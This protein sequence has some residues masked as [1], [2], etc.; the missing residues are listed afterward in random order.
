[1]L[2]YIRPGASL[3]RHRNSGGANYGTQRPPTPPGLSRP[4]QG[5]CAG[6]R[7]PIRLPQ[8]TPD[9]GFVPGGS[10]GR[11]FKSG[12]PDQKFPGQKG[13]P[14]YH[15]GPFSIFGSQSGSL[16]VRSTPVNAQSTRVRSARSTVIRSRSTGAAGTQ[17]VGVSLVSAGPG[18]LRMRLGEAAVQRDGATGHGPDASPQFA[19]GQLADRDCD[20]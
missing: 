4:L 1:V 12:R 5:V 10:R 17:T 11:R 8:T 3:S 19:G 18:T 6:E 14:G 16:D 9:T 7:L 20:E 13:V 2:V 15:S